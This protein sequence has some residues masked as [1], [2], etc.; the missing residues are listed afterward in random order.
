MTSKATTSKATTSKATTSKQGDTPLAC[1]AEDVFEDDVTWQGL[2]QR[3]MRTSRLGKPDSAV[4]QVREMARCAMA[5]GLDRVLFAGA[6]A[7]A[8]AYVSALLDASQQH[9][10]LEPRS[11]M[12]RHGVAGVNLRVRRRLS[13]EGSD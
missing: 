11:S 9:S 4:E 13:G 6:S 10:S 3:A 2:V 8:V 12:P 1:Q 7:E 5:S